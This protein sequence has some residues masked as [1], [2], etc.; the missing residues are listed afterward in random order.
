LLADL[1][2]MLHAKGIEPDLVILGGDYTTK[3]LRDLHPDAIKALSRL[4][5]NGA[6]GVFIL[7]NKDYEMGD[8]EGTKRLVSSAGFEYLSNS[9]RQ[10]AVK[11]VE[12]AVVGMNT[13]EGGPQMPAFPQSFKPA[14]K[15]VAT[16]DF[17]KFPLGL[18][19]G[20]DAIFAG[21]WHAGFDAMP[22]AGIVQA[23]KSPDFRRKVTT[24]RQNSEVAVAPIGNNALIDQSGGAGR[25]VIYPKVILGVKTPDWA[26]GPSDGSINVITFKGT[27]TAK[28]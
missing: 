19:E 17:D 10:I 8:T 7:G 28:K 13:Y 11:G 2:K 9:Y 6:K 14:M 25:Y 4:L 22:I 20:V 26:S 24:R 1:P 5:Q 18:A 23:V 3:G 16:H 21:H 27:G 15:I 12:I